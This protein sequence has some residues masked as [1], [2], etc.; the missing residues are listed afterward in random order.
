[1]NKYSLLIDVCTNECVFVVFNNHF[2]DKLIYH[3]NKNLVD[4][5]N[6]LLDELLKK[7]KIKYSNIDKIYVVNGPGSFTG[8]R[9]GLNMAKTI[10]SVFNHIQL[11]TIDSLLALNIGNGIS[12]IDAKGDK[13]YF[14]AAKNKQILQPTIMIHNNQLEKYINKYKDL[15][16]VNSLNI[17]IENKINQLLNNLDLFKYQEDWLNV[18]PNYVKEAV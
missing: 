16:I 9:A 3:T 14:Q 4:V 18:E 10:I 7:N 1:M 6:S 8:V 17:N 13:S 5:M 11:F 2:Q 12:I 15:S